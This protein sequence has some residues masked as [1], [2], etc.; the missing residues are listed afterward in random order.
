[1]IDRTVE[2]D[3]DPASEADI[4]ASATAP[5]VD[6]ER[7]VT[8]PVSEP[9][10][11]QDLDQPQANPQPTATQETRQAGGDL[12]VALREERAALKAL[13]A[14]LD[15]ERAERA[16]L[17]RMLPQPQQ[18][19]AKPAE[20]PVDPL[21]MMLDKPEEWGKSIV[22]P[23]QQQVRTVVEHF[24]RR[25][26]V[27]EHGAEKVQ[28]AYSALASAMA[29]GEINRDATLAALQQSMDPFGDIMGW[30]ESRPENAEKRIREKVLEELRASGQLPATA[31]GQP[32]APPATAG[33]TNL[34]SLTRATGNAGA[35]QSGSITDDDIFNA[36][37]AFGR[38]RKA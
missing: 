17:L 37:P 12:S 10:T 23:V 24:S 6:D 29:R 3:T 4:F 11:E 20:P 35:P 16:Q 32:Q 8:Q 5:S 34:P 36:A 15:R 14:E 19:P 27:R 26:A 38:S 28:E 25:E 9:E 7:P 33:N 2:V 18:P 30:H 1:M 22:E 31:P 21:T 13:K